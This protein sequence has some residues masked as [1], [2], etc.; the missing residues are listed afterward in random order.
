MR[1]I[2]EAT[3]QSAPN[4]KPHFEINGDHPLVQRLD[5]EPDEDRFSDM[6]LI[7]FDQASL[8]DGTVLLEPGEYVQRINRLLLN[9]L[10]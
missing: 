1:R 10:E 3:G 4:S 8:A 6:V 9:L 7:L 5:T 2:M